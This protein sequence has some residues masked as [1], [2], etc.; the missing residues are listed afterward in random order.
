[1]LLHLEGEQ[2]TSLVIGSSTAQQRHSGVHHVSLA[3][4]VYGSLSCTISRCSQ[5]SPSGHISY[6]LKLKNASPIF[7]S[8]GDCQQSW[9]F[10]FS[11]DEVDAEIRRQDALSAATKP[12]SVDRDQLWADMR[13]QKLGR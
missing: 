12:S 2:L 8:W 3:S 4:F 5:S 11:N 13:R 6:T 10:V 9:S 1:L 7:I